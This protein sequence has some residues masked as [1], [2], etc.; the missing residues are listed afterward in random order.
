MKLIV[1]QI[2]AVEQFDSNKLAKY[3]RC[4]FQATLPWGDNTALQLVDQAM[5]VAKEGS[6]VS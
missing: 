5:Q 6:Q 2:F 3:I 1:N 4:I